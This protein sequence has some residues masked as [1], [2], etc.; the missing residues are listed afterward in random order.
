MAKPKNN[1]TPYDRLSPDKQSDLV[2]WWLRNHP[3][4][5]ITAAEGKLSAMS[6]QKLQDLLEQ[7]ETRAAGVISTADAQ[8]I[9][10]FVARMQKLAKD[11]RAGGASPDEIAEMVK[12]ELG[13]F[14]QTHPEA[15][16]QLNNEPKALKRLTDILA[17]PKKDPLDKTRSVGA[18]PT[19]NIGNRTPESAKRADDLLG[20][21]KPVNRSESKDPLTTAIEKEEE[22][23]ARQ[24]GAPPT[25]TALDEAARL[26]R[27]ELEKILKKPLDELTLPELAQRLEH[28]KRLLD[29]K[30]VE[31][32]IAGGSKGPEGKK[33]AGAES[34]EDLA[35]RRQAASLGVKYHV[36]LSGDPVKDAASML[37]E[38]DNLLAELDGTDVG[39]GKLGE[40]RAL[41]ARLA[42]DVAMGTLSERSVKRFVKLKGELSDTLNTMTFERQRADEL[43][44]TA[45]Q[46][47]E[48]KARSARIKVRRA[49]P[50]S[51]RLK[52]LREEIA[53]RA[54]AASVVPATRT[55][56]GGGKVAPPMGTSSLLGKKAPQFLQRLTTGNAL[57]VGMAVLAPLILDSIISGTQSSKAQRELMEKMPQRTSD[58]ILADME[59]ARYMARQAATQKPA[60][61]PQILIMLEMMNRPKNQARFEKYI[62]PS[63]LEM[64]QRQG[65]TLQDLLSGL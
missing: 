15:A 13:L 48:D 28:K 27:E 32:Q 1:L 39:K 50:R 47:A 44:E 57:G 5:S 29:L 2:D 20:S 63:G 25:T 31:D 65:V 56:L 19:G 4:D 22:A 43:R 33:P 26:R 45:V 46:E 38:I 62:G 58:D 42:K 49:M 59:N 16:R 23:L 64:A 60:I 40:L 21:G 52:R 24:A 6:S 8:T 12:G 18:L 55:G 17:G 11:A 53:E 7:L 9:D 37:D 54:R 14:M 41:R 10:D 34:A 30:K 3:R 36:A 61:D 51:M 35:A